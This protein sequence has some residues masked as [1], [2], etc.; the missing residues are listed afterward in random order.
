M[1]PTRRIVLGGGL[2]A[3]LWRLGARARADAPAPAAEGILNFEAAPSRLQLFPP[4][5]EPATAYAYADAIP[6]PLIRL[7]QGQELR[8]KLTNKL[9]EP[10]TLS[11]PGLRAANATAGIGGLT[12]ERLKPDASAEIRFIPPDSGFNLYL[13]RAGSTDAS[14]QGRGLFGPIIVDEPKAPDVDLDAAVVLS[15]WDVDASG[16]IEDDFAD[17]A[18][19]RGSGRKGGVVFANGATAPLKLKARPGA[20]VRLRLGSAATARLAT[21]AISGAKIHI[22]AVD[23][24][25][26]EPFEPLAN[27]FP[28]GPGAR[29]ELMFDMPRNPGADVRLDLRGDAGAA[30]QPFVAIVSEGEP[31]DARSGSPRLAANPRL[32]AEIALESARRCDFAISGGGPAPFAINGATFIDWAPKPAYVIPRGQPT[33]FSLA[34]KTA[35]V[36]AIRLWGH[37]A[38]LLHSMDDGWEPY[39]RDTILIQPG[40]SAHVAFVADN[41]GKWPLE[42]AIPEHRAAGVG[43]WFQVG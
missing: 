21:I 20:R 29:F 24:Q 11:F 42:S 5:A 34:N 35:V 22:A 43:T 10:T 23:G 39:W 4:P 3:A 17:P 32:P 18:I 14:Q 15:D 33:V 1:T 2:A 6:G 30:D 16:R 40:R 27:Q 31:M 37:V 26:S 41:P 19:G 12:Q 38:R 9:A 13:P 36:Q 7:R 25:P 8:L 28:M